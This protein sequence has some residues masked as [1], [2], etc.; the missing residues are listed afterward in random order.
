MDLDVAHLALFAG[1]AFND[2]VERELRKRNPKVR[3]SWGYVIQHLIGA[4]RSIGELALRMEVTQQAASK[5]V[6][7]LEKLGCVERDVDRGD[8]RVVRVKLSERGERLVD[9]SRRVRAK[10]NEKLVKRV[11]Q[12]KIERTRAV[13]ADIIDELGGMERVKTR[14]IVPR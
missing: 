1:Y 7:E 8:A 14:R 13:L 10:W 3:T 6:S 2:V 11:G 9:E 5:A 4:S 12:K